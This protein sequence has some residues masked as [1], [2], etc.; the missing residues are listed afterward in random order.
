TG[1]EEFEII[2]KHISIF[3]RPEENEKAI[4][5]L[6]KASR[7]G[8][9]IVTGLR[10]KKRGVNFWAKMKIQFL[11]SSESNGPCFKVILQDTT[12][13]ALSKERMRTLRDEYL[14]LFNNPFV[15]TFKFKVDGYSIQMCNQKT[16]EF[17]GRAT[18]ANLSFDSFFAYHHQF[19][20]FI[21]QLRE[22]KKV[23]GFK[24][25]V[26][27]GNASHETWALASARY[28]EAHGF[29]EGVLFDITEQYH[30]MMELQRVNTE[31]DNF[32]YHASHDLR[33]PLTSIM[34]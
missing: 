27:N 29:A 9:A 1:Y 5:D 17:L 33:S 28:F 2:G 12:H 13:R 20:Q 23:E 16:L 7:L 30:Q 11:H 26:Q 8:S 21:S 22:D 19:E 10:V 6:E 3:Y 14:S 31:L 32:I 18:S 15:G 34:G 24:F 25:L 4:A